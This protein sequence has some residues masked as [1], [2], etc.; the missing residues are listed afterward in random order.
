MNLPKELLDI[1]RRARDAWELESAKLS[2]R[3]EEVEDKVTGAIDRIDDC[4][5]DVVRIKDEMEVH[6]DTLN[7]LESRLRDLEGSESDTG[8]RTVSREGERLVDSAQAFE[9]RLSAIEG[10][11][12]NLTEVVVSINRSLAHTNAVTGVH[13][14]DE[15]YVTHRDTFTALASRIGELELN[16]NEDYSACE[17]RLTELERQM[18][19][20]V[21]RLDALV[22]LI[23]RGEY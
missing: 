13:G 6:C 3:V 2:E 12:S 7:N 10:K 19:V 11:M 14:D 4:E 8:E 15:E 17:A 5:D 9:A 1:F 21:N 18:T 23:Q 22:S 20:L 16:E